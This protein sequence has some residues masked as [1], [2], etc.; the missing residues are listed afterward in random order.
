MHVST[1]RLL[2]TQYEPLRYYYCNACMFSFAECLSEAVVAGELGC[3]SGVLAGTALGLDPVVMRCP[4]S[5]T[6]LILEQMTELSTTEL[7]SMSSLVSVQ[8]GR[9]GIAFVTRILTGTCTYVAVYSQY[10][11]T[12]SLSSNPGCQ[13]CDFYLLSSFWKWSS[14]VK[15][16]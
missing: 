7:L 10:N 14:D 12:E 2:M 5:Q 8:L 11:F 3:M 15:A 16:K 1:S 6:I 9:P 13:F 4:E